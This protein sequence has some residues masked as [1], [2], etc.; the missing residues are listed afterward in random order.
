[1]LPGRES[2]FRSLVSEVIFGGED[3]VLGLRCVATVSDVWV[4][5]LPI[6]EGKGEGSDSDDDE[7]TGRGVDGGLV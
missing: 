2:E 7:G 4:E 3:G 5:G 1:M 6:G